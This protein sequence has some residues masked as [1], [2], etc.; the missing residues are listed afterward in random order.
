MRKKYL[1]CVLMI[2]IV[3]SMGCSRGDS[4]K[5][6]FQRYIA[7]WQKHDYKGMYSAL[8]TY[9][10]KRIEEKEFVSRYTNIYNG[11]KL[12]QITITPEYPK[13]FKK[14]SNGNTPIPFEVVMN[15]AAGEIKFKDTAYFIKD[16]STKEW[17][18]SWSS[19]LIFPQLKNDYK[20]R[21]TTAYG[22]RGE[23]KTADGKYLAQNGYIYSVGIVPNKL[24]KDSKK[25]KDTIA[26]IL[27]IDKSF[28]NKRLSAKFVKPYMFIQ[29]DS[30][31]MDDERVYKLK[32]INGVM[33]QKVPARVYPLK[34]KAALLTGYVHPITA[35]ELQKLRKEG[36]D[37]NDIIGKAGLE[38]IYEKQLKATDG[39]EIYIT[40]ENGDKVKSLAKT[41]K[42]D[43]KDIHLTID[44]DIQSEVYGQYKASSGAAV[45]M[46]PK[47]GAVLALVSAPGYDPNDFV[48]G[49]SSDKWNSLQNNEKKPFLNRFQSTFA[50]G[51]TFKPLTAIMGLKTGKLNPNVDA[52]ISGLKW[53]KDKSWGK[54]HVTRDETYSGPSNLLNALVYSDN[55]YFAKA[56]LNIGKEN[57]IDE[58][59]KLG[60]G[61]NIP[62]EYGLKTSQISSDGTIK[63][64]VQL[65]DSGYGQAQVLINPVQLASIYTSFVNNGNIITPYL[66]VDTGTPSK[67]WISHVYS[68]NILNMVFNDMKQIVKNPEGTAHKAYM[69]DL[70]LAG[71]TGTAEI[72]KSQTDTTGTENG[73]FVAVNTD[74]PKLLVLEM[75][76]NV[77]HR[78]G[79]GYVVP[80]V[81]E[82]FDKFCK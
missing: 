80:K 56:A 12:S 28:I 66:N 33:L 45:V 54:Y 30:I 50:P 5:E 44:A 67:I 17:R 68:E 19:K 11:I 36:Y 4:P 41:V 58:T 47:T 71:K 39:K 2:I 46:Q 42:K 43:G 61:E 7:A 76:E 70:P 62:F 79:S 40:D 74:K 24:G 48:L 13:V 18:L 6:A 53:Q 77:K 8:D 75:H 32:Q 26:K 65:A 14:D 9:S 37:E 3:F 82:I 31:S 64:D 22:K 21:I 51:S 60:I 16:T 35:E 72:K 23:I 1:F 10:R 57:F 63:S 49:M 29:I 52:K 81:K 27:N 20:V 38:K 34:E 55:I 78:G 59:K 25:T 73:W 69:A 15:T